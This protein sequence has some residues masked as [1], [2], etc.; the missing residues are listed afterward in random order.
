MKLRPWMIATM[1]AALFGVQVELAE[2]STG[3]TREQVQAGRAARARAGRGLKGRTGGVVE[4]HPARC[5]IQVGD[6]TRGLAGAP[7][8]DRESPPCCGHTTGMKPGLRCVNR[9]VFA[10]RANMDC[11]VVLPSGH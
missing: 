6:A 10:Q 7:V 3:L 4:I 8:S 9:V 1:M 2:A 5:R 11:R